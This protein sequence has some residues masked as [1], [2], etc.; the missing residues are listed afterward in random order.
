MSSQGS[1]SS[2]LPLGLGLCCFCCQKCL[3]SSPPYSWAQTAPARPPP[4]PSPGSGSLPHPGPSAAALVLLTHSPCPSPASQRLPSVLM[5]TQHCAQNQQG[6]NNISALRVL[7]FLL[8]PLFL[9]PSK[10]GR[11]GYPE[12]LRAWR[13]SSFSGHTWIPGYVREPRDRGRASLGFQNHQSHRDQVILGW[14]AGGLDLAAVKNYLKFFHGGIG[15]H[16]QPRELFWDTLAGAFCSCPNK[17]TPSSQ[18]WK[19]PP[20]LFTALPVFAAGIRR[21]AW[22]R[23]AQVGWSADRILKCPDPRMAVWSVG[24]AGAS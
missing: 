18:A 13:G 4:G 20:T 24:R 8:W 23:S 11:S 17:L 10:A 6:P 16:P 19:F 14:L 1:G 15:S 9:H 3:S 22:M 7:V 2:V 12:G 21:V 5:H